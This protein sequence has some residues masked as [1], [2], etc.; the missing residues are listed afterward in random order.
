[1]QIARYQPSLTIQGQTPPQPLARPIRRRSFQNEVLLEKYDRYL[2]VIEVSPH[3]RRAYA[4]WVKRFGEH[5]DGKNFATASKVEIRAWLAT[6][7]E[8][9]LKRA[10]QAQAVHALRSFYRFMELGDQVLFSPPRQ[11]LT[12]K[13]EIRL[14]HALSVKEVE[15]LIEATQTPRDRA[16]LE[17]AFA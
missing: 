9:K 12:P 8:R 2:T 14:P 5:L 4:L 11:V 7:Y 15:Q 1:M 10:T 13:V 6:V 17:L 3:T 16:L